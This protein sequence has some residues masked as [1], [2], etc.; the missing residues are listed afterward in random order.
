MKLADKVAVVTGGGTGI[1]R[2]ISLLFGAEGAK[3]LVNYARSRDEAEAVVREICAGGGAAAAHQA[4]VTDPAQV[5]QMMDAVKSR[6]SRLDV[7]VNNAGWSTR[8]PHDRLDDLTDEIWDRTLNTNLKAPFYCARAAAPLLGEQPGS[9]IV[10]VASATAFNAGGSSMAY[11]A[12]KAGLVTMTRSLARVLAPGIRVNAVCPGLVPTRFAGW[13]AEAFE[14]AR[15]VTPLGRLPA[16]EEVAKAVLFL[17][18][19][20]T[21]LTGEALV[22]D[23]GTFQL[24][25]SR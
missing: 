10:N 18:A 7:L 13:P 11:A 16:V 14:R 8:V 19:D 9:C 6:W 4:D 17:A 2:A 23:G 24:G 12:A 20:G 1:G 3:V 25:R 5:R 15:E 21:A 22:I